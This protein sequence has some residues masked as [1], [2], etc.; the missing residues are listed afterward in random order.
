MS[1]SMG[2]A[3]FSKK[4][5]E[6]VEST[7]KSKI[8]EE[9]KTEK[10][11]IVDS[12]TKP[13]D[14]KKKESIAKNEDESAA[15]EEH[16]IQI[17]EAGKDVKPNANEEEIAK[18]EEETAKKDAE[19]Q[20]KDETAPVT[21]NKTSES[22]KENDVVEEKSNDVNND[23]NED[24]T[25]QSEKPKDEDVVITEEQTETKATTDGTSI[26]ETVTAGVKRKD[27]PV[28]TNDVDAEIDGKVKRAKVNKVEDKADEA[29]E[30]ANDVEFSSSKDAVVA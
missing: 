30:K 15:K 2:N 26:G 13:E 3:L 1:K 16:N 6:A 22:L 9:S 14:E 29:I 7:V 12:S 11:E 28:T 8:P 20:L 27:S 24:L 18:K 10:V 4:E 5:E 25:K 17:E 19:D 21:I 23:G